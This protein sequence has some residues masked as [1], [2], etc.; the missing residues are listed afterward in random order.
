MLR[1]G[2]LATMLPLVAEAI[3]INNAAVLRPDDSNEL[4][5]LDLQGPD[6]IDRCMCVCSVYA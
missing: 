5:H 6:R 3:D 1:V 4:E 2:L